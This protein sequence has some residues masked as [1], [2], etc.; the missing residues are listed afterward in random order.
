MVKHML[1]CVDDKRHYANCLPN[2]SNKN[3]LTA[4]EISVSSWNKLL[5]FIGGALET[6]K[7]AWYLITWNFD[8]DDS[9]FI[10]SKDEEL[11]ITMHDGTKIQSTKIQPNQATTYL[12]VTSQVDGDQSAQTAVIKKRPTT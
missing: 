5:H 11:N 12:G 7:C 1:A 10:K 4:M 3:I 8:S 9:S 2:Q 6:S